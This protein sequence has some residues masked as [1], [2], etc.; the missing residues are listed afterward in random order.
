MLLSS[1]LYPLTL[2]CLLVYLLPCLLT[3]LFN[4]IYPSI[5]PSIHLGS[6]ETLD[7]WNRQYSHP[8]SEVLLGRFI[9][10]SSLSPTAE[11]PTFSASGWAFTGFVSGKWHFSVKWNWSWWWWWCYEPQ[12][13]Q[14]L[15]LATRT[16][17]NIRIKGCNV[18]CVCMCLCVA[19][20]PSTYPPQSLEI[21][22]PR[23]PRA[24][25]NNREGPPNGRVFHHR[26][27]FLGSQS[28]NLLLTPLE[29]PCHNFSI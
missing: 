28:S 3:Y 24:Y 18:M 20:A 7:S 13:K 2:S 23:V 14:W 17:N 1:L 5:H 29:P 19:T 9:C 16:K 15:R 8:D 22:D 11:F 12:H 27:S 26:W 25:S 4:S 6:Y 10:Q 21:Q